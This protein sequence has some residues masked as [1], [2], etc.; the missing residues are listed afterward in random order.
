MATFEEQL[1][2]SRA[3]AQAWERGDVDAAV[4]LTTQDV[5]F[6]SKLVGVEGGAY[7]GHDGLR[8]YFA[9]IT[10]TLTERRMTIEEADDFGDV[11]LMRATM[12]AIGAASRTPLTWEIWPVTHYEDG[13]LIS[14]SIV[15]ASRD[16]ALAAEGLAGR[17]PLQSLTVAV[18]QP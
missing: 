13:G 12:G 8:A 17:E 2:V 1:A 15:Y 7:R 6:K 4:A 5:E 10:D 3:W 11:A 16:E 18:D 14:S 9:D